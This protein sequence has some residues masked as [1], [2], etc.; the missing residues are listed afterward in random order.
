MKLT[1]QLATVLLAISLAGCASDSSPNPHATTSPSISSA[2]SPEFWRTLT[3]PLGGNG[4]VSPGSFAVIVPRDDIDLESEMGEIP[5]TAGIESRFYFFRCTCGKV[6]VIG[7]FLACDY[8]SNDVLDALRDGRITIV[9]IAPILQN[10][11]PQLVSIRFQGE[12]DG[13]DLVHTLREALSAAARY[14][15]KPHIPQ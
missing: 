6:K 1:A 4:I 2:D 14:H 9:S 13:D 3:A 7:D 15:R 10:T 12:G 11:R 8:E 5:T